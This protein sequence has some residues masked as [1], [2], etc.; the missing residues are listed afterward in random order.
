MLPTTP[1]PQTSPTGRGS[2]F[3]FVES[4]SIRFHFPRTQISRM[5]FLD[6]D[7]DVRITRPCVIQIILR[8]H[9]P[10]VGV[11]MIEPY[12]VQT[13]FARILLAAHQFL[14]PNQ[15]AIAFSCLF[16]GV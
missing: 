12:D 13:L 3:F 6:R 2:Y 14:R 9:G 5:S 11:R 16:A 15:K 1:S 4:R 7:D 8:R 10:I